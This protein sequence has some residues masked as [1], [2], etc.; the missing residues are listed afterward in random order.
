MYYQ[1]MNKIN[2]I[3]P[4]RLKSTGDWVFDDERFDLIQEPFVSG[5]PQL[6]DYL[7]ADITNASDG[8]KLLFSDSAFPN[9]SM[10]LSFNREEY[11][12]WWY[13]CSGMSGWL[14][15]A[16]QNYFRHGPPDNIFIKAEALYDNL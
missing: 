3:K 16:A 2:I 12:G 5:A 1:V 14:C 6:I 7:V 8:F 11:G 9:Y 13:E 15:A 10:I 4:Y